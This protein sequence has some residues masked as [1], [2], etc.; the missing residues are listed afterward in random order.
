M[1]PSFGWILNLN[2]FHTAL[3]ICHH[4]SPWEGIMFWNEKMSEDE[5]FQT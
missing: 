3:S 5:C 2:H 1:L 4:T